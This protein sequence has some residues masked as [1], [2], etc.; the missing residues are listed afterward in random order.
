MVEAWDAWGQ[1]A[2]G[3]CRLVVSKSCQGVLAADL[4]RLDASV[5]IIS[6]YQ[7]FVVGSCRLIEI[8]VAVL[9]LESRS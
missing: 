5:L 1:I 2:D 9:S 3:R 4:P 6:R 7:C 8:E